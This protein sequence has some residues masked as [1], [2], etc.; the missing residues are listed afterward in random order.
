[1]TLTTQVTTPAVPTE[2]VMLIKQ[3]KNPLQASGRM[4]KTPINNPGEIAKRNQSGTVVVLE[5]TYATIAAG[6]DS[7]MET[8]A[9][10]AV[11]L[12]IILKAGDAHS[13]QHAADC[14]LHLSVDF[15][16]GFIDG[17]EDQILEHFDV[18]GFHRFGIDAEAEKLLTAI[19][20]C[21]DGATAGCGLDDS[22]LHFFLQGFVLRFGFGHQLL[23]IE[24]THGNWEIWKLGNRV[25]L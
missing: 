5:I 21:G 8:R 24:A 9:R 14:G 22:L 6:I 11:V 20:F 18:A 10:L 15:A 23:K 16:S 4:A 19:H 3:S 13:A 17:G 2:A 25:V 1:M 7:I 12:R